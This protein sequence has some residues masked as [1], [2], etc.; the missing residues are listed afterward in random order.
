MSAFTGSKSCT[1]CPA[2]RY[3]DVSGSTSASC[4]GPCGAGSSQILSLPCSTREMRHCS[5]L[6]SY[7]HYVLCADVTR[8]VSPAHC[9]ASS[10]TIL[11][12]LCRLLLR[13][14]LH[15]VHVQCVFGGQV[16]WDWV[17]GMQFVQRGPIRRI[18]RSHRRELLRA[19]HAR[20]LLPC[21][22]LQRH[23]YRVSSGC[24]DVSP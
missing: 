5:R 23:R 4:V 18:T 8:G 20:L 16:E 7:E 17:R 2:G 24:V 3:A 13:G 22:L 12:P 10:L 6:L 21:R 9:P 15:G 14:R 1:L 19:V 11:L